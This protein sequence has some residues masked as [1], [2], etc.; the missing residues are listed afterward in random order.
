MRSLK[1]SRSLNSI[2][3]VQISLYFDVLEK[4]MF[5][6]NLEKSCWI[7]APFLSEATEA[8]LYY[9]FEYRLMRLKSPNLRNTQIPSFRPKKC[10]LLASEVFKVCQIQ[11]KDPVWISMEFK[12]QFLNVEDI[13]SKQQLEHKRT[14]DNAIPN[15]QA[16]NFSKIINSNYLR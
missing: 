3:W 5:W 6:Q 14:L 10:F 9:F 2:I 15:I 13:K 8:I 1:S 7:L 16:W 11:S 12:I 4:K